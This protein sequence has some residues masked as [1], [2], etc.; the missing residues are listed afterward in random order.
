MST[1]FT[2][3]QTQNTRI[4]FEEL[5]LWVRSRIQ[6]WVQ[7]LLEEEVT[8]ILGRG[9][10]ERRSRIDVPKG[11]RNGYGKPRRL[12]LSC[13][14]IKVSRPRVRDLEERFESRILP[15]FAR[16]TKELGDLIPELYLHGLSQGGRL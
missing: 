15:L 1:E 12:S 4:I 6:Q 13:G 3:Q 16:R 11:Y 8:G 14:T 9:K 7:E 10:S 2:Q 5:E